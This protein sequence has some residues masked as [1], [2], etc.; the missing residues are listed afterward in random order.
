MPEEE[1]TATIA[2]YWY[3][4]GFQGFK[5]LGYEPDAI[6]SCL[7][8]DVELDG[9]SISVRSSTTLSTA[10]ICESML[11]LTAYN[12]T[13]IAIINGGTVR[14]DD[15]LRETITQYDIIRTLPFGNRV[16]ALSVPG[17]L[18]AQVL[19]KGTSLKGNG[20]FIAYTRVETFDGGNT[21]L[22][23]GTDISKSGLYYDVATT[24]YIRDFTQLN[25]SY[26]ITLHNANVTQTKSLMQ[27]LTIKYSPC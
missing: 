13:T 25:K 23:N 9:R 27:Y 16:I 22:L 6:V 2:N 21:W 7:R 10:E 4:L 17:H 1:N 20:I 15:I 8:I 11:K 14:I 24:A 18:L 3:N 12:Q 26:V 19:T 5:E